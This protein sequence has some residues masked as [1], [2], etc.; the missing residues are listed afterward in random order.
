[1]VSGESDQEATAQGNGVAVVAVAV[2]M[3][4]LFGGMALCRLHALRVRRRRRLAKVPEDDRATHFPL[5]LADEA[6][7]PRAQENDGGSE[8][9]RTPRTRDDEFR[10][11][12]PRNE[13]DASVD[14]YLA[15]NDRDDRERGHPPERRRDADPSE[16]DVRRRERARRDRPTRVDYDSDGQSVDPQLLSDRIADP[17]QDVSSGS[18]ETRVS[19]PLSQLREG[20]RRP[21]W[22]SESASPSGVGKAARPDLVN[23]SRQGRRE[24][25]GTQ[26]GEGGSMAYGRNTCDASGD[27]ALGHDETRTSANSSRPESDGG[28][29][30]EDGSST[31]S[32]SVDDGERPTGRSNVSGLGGVRGEAALTRRPSRRETLAATAREP[33]PAPSALPP[34]SSRTLFGGGGR[35][36][37]RGN[38]DR[39]SRGRSA[40]P[41][42][43]SAVSE[44]LVTVDEQRSGDDDES[45]SV[46]SFTEDLERKGN[47]SAAAGTS[48]V[49][50]SKS[51]K[52]EGTVVSGLVRKFSFERN[53]TKTDHRA[54]T[55]V[56][57]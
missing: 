18:G 57:V 14:S 25:C 12:T 44:P 7:D 3:V 8:S 52:I 20:S 11:Y 1:M 36:H 28:E 55:S 19:V 35:D 45:G 40:P 2:G 56:H 6:S 53:E 31:S 22:L 32:E 37:P 17:L 21:S 48:A 15:W 30:D 27:R 42:A 5:V 26:G 50:S 43:R 49:L 4:G 38:A 24:K 23:A 47:G 34:P 39:R 9:P 46:V 51:P 33:P 54:Q 10:A 13:R 29:D 41:S 16:A